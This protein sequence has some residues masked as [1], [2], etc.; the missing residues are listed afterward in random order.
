MKKTC[1]NC[2]GGQY[3]KVIR[4]E[5]VAYKWCDKCLDLADDYELAG[6]HKRKK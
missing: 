3:P 6:W 2:E 4:G 1:F 5:L